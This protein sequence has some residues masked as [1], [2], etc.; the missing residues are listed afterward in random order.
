MSMDPS[1]YPPQY[2]P[3]SGYGQPQQPPSGSGYEQPPAYGYAPPSYPMYGQPVA[4]PMPTK[5]SGWAIA[6][7][8]CSIVGVSLL[9]VIF[10]HIALNEIKKSN[11]MVEGHGLALAGVIIGYVGLGIGLCVCAIYGI[12]IAAVLTNPSAYPTPSG[13]VGLLPW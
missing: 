5:T 6:S 8:I 10:G 12:G 9:G 2:P 13:F 7:L 3:A 11:G 1:Q 4:A